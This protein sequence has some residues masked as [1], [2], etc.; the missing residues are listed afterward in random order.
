MRIFSY[1]NKRA[2]RRVVLIALGVVALL[3]LLL[4]CRFIYL[5]RYV[6][7]T[8]DGQAHLDYTQK[9]APT[10]AVPEKLDPA[11]FPFETVLNATPEPSGEQAVMQQL[12]G[13]YISTHMLADGVDAVREQLDSLENYN[14]VLLDVKSIYG[15]FYYS[16]ELSGAQTAS[17][18]VVD[19]SAVDA[20]I[21][22]LTARQDLTVIA[23][24]PAFSDPVYALAHQS[25]GLP[26]SSGA[27]WTDENG[28]YW[29]NPYSN[30]VQGY[31]SSIALELAQFGFDE[32]LFDGFYFPDTDRISWNTDAVTREGA[33]LDA[34]E[35]IKDNLFG[36]GIRVCFG[37]DSAEVASFADRIFLSSSDPESV[38]TLTQSMQQVLTEPEKQ[39]VFLTSS[40]D[41]RFEACSVIRPLI[42]SGTLGE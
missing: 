33:V 10:G 35:H 42:D 36:S 30:G 23:R 24:V 32:V 26:L 2:L 25:E 29:L 27:L 9:L 15:N 3:L 11:E 5:G 41:T 7:Y 39:I 13:Y 16:T 4:V 6:V 28:C 40:R 17:A 34:A 12:T 31:L 20:L 8:G 22:D 14:A 38:P 37:T 21:H 1:R 19:I 18:D